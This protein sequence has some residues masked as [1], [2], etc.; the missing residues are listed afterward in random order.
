MIVCGRH[1]HIL[2]QSGVNATVSTFTDDV[3]TM[4][5]PIIDAIIAYDCPDTRKIWLLVVRNVL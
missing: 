5:V 3:D 1:C 2:L 4:N